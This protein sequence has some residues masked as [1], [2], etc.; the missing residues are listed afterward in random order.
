MMADA[1]CC[2]GILSWCV[3]Q[4]KMGFHRDRCWQKVLSMRVL[5]GISGSS[6]GRWAV[7]Q[8][9]TGAWRPLTKTGRRGQAE[10]SPSAALGWGV[11]SMPESYS[12]S[13]K[14]TEAQGLIPQLPTGSCWG[15]FNFFFD[16]SSL[17]GLRAEDAPTARKQASRQRTAGIHTSAFSPYRAAV[18]GMNGADGFLQACVCVS[19]RVVHMHA[20]T[21]VK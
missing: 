15:L 13:P 11:L 2:V 20:S 6:D 19:A 8:W 21:D 9:G 18:K 1:T 5:G 10:V 12:S 16:T 3:I 4:L 7:R 17:Q 14:H